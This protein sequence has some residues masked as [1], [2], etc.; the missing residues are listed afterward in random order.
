MRL[1]PEGEFRESP[2]YKRDVKIHTYAHQDGA[3]YKTKV[4]FLVFVCLIWLLI[5][6]FLRIQNHRQLS[7][8]PEFTVF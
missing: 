5:F 6:F 8:K 1:S 3:G 2:Y 4:E 7:S